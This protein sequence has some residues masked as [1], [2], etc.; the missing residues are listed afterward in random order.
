MR[1]FKL[2]LLIAI[3]LNTSLSNLF[4]IDI[5]FT[6]AFA[7]ILLLIIL[8]S[9]AN[10]INY[11]IEQNSLYLIAIISGILYVILQFFNGENYVKNILF[12]FIPIIFTL[13]FEKLTNKYTK[14]IRQTILLFFVV[15]CLLAIIERVF[16][17]NTFEFIE[18]AN[19][20][21]TELYMREGWQFRSTA[22]LGHPLANAMAVVTI[23]SFIVISDMGKLYKIFLFILGY[24]AVFSFNAR[25][26]IIVYS[27]IIL[28]YFIYNLM[29][30]TKYRKDKIK[31]IIL[32]TSIISIFVFFIINSEFGGRLFN[33]DNAI[34]DGST[35]TRIEVFEFY[36]H[37]NINEL[38]LGNPQ[39]YQIIMSALGAGGVENGII[40][41]LLLYGI[42]F[43]VFLL[44]VLFKLQLLG[45]QTYKKK[46]K[47]FLISVFYII[48]TM[49]PNLAIL[50]QWMI[51]I[52]CMYSFK[53]STYLSKHKLNIGKMVIN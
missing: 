51:F 47:W 33:S 28:P 1:Y 16:S 9:Y 18:Y 34:I 26:A 37:I 49:N 40:T 23:S 44:Y 48:G 46:N 19:L 31:W 39:N 24:A 30:S 3:F 36:K 35:L 7:P 14:Q 15:E 32:L 5:V 38:I 52:F 17:F 20:T 6:V 12:L 8:T 29:K 21:E 45:L 41:I 11:F 50:L 43:G 25:G 22:L 13:Y 2:V 4:G 42:I 53:N 27:I 10:N